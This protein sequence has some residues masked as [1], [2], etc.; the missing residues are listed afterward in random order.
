MTCLLHRIL[1]QLT[2]A[3]FPRYVISSSLTDC[4]S[5][6]GMMSSQLIVASGL[7]AGLDKHAL[8]DTPVVVLVGRCHGVH[9]PLP[10]D[11]VSVLLPCDAQVHAGAR[12]LEAHS[13]VTLPHLP[14]ALDRPHVQVIPLAVLPERTHLLETGAGETRRENMR[15]SWEGARLKCTCCFGIGKYGTRT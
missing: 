2:T 4:A 15:L 8:H 12:V 11:G 7:L 1:V 3:A 10:A 5:P 9:L 6:H 13:V 14:A